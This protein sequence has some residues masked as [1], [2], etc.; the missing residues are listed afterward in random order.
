[1]LDENRDIH[2]RVTVSI[3]MSLPTF[4]L[5]QA[6]DQKLTHRLHG[7]APDSSVDRQASRLVHHSLSNDPD[8]EAAA[9]AINGDS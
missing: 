4:G 8:G 6:A 7:I 2:M 1:M 9:V 5:E 3:L